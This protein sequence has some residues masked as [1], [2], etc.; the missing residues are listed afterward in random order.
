MAAGGRQLPPTLEAALHTHCG[1]VL[2]TTSVAAQMPKNWT[3]HQVPLSSRLA[4]QLRPS[5]LEQLF[6]KQH[7]TSVSGD[8]DS[9]TARAAEPRDEVGVVRVTKSHVW[10]KVPDWPALRYLTSHKMLAGTEYFCSV[11][12][13][14]ALTFSGAQ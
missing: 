6:L 13:G 12:Y 5:S 2:K 11:N 14:Q 3:A 10:T 1:N 4:H 7:A 8:S 9:V